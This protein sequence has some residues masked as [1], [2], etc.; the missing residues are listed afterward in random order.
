MRDRR[1]QD[2]R[3]QTGG[4]AAVRSRRQ[5]PVRQGD[6]GRPAAPATWTSRSTAARTCRRCC[7]TGSRSGAVLPREDPRDVL[8]LPGGP[9]AAGD[10]RGARWRRLGP[11]R[12]HRHEQRAADRRARPAVARRVVRADSR[13]SRHAAAQAGPR[14]VY[15]VTGAGRGRAC[16]GSGSPTRIS[17]TLPLDACVPAPGPGR[18]CRSSCA[19][20]TRA[21][22]RRCG[23]RPPGDRRGPSRRSGRSWPR[24]AAAARRRSGRSPLADGDELDLQAVVVSLDG[25]RAVR[26]RRP[27]AASAGRRRS[28]RAS[29]GSWSPREPTRFSRTCAARRPARP[30]AV[31]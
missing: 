26:G 24:S 30:E 7:P 28:A 27:G 11:A 23:H 15:D 8:V 20:T 18:D 5:A 25:H 19:P 21:R 1:H 22:A 9:R 17:F 2:Q 16:G 10:D 31:R 29:R 6:R 4:G 3:R 12:A 13:E 14:R